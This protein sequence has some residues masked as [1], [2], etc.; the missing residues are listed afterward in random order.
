MFK[1]L[2]VKHQRYIELHLR[3]ISTK[4]LSVKRGVIRLIEAMERMKDTC[5]GYGSGFR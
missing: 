4:E 1:P 3:K 5:R 2:Q